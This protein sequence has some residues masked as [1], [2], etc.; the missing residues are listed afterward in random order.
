MGEI[1]TLRKADG[2]VAEI[3]L[4]ARRYLDSARQRIADDGVKATLKAGTSLAL[5]HATYPA[6]VR[7]Q[8]RRTFTFRGTS[9]HYETS[10]WNNAWLNER[11]V[12]IAVARNVLSGQTGSMLEVGNVLGHYGWDRHVILDLF[13]GL[14]GVI[15]EDVRTW[16]TDQRFST[17]ASISTLE[18]VGWDDPVKDPRGAVASV[19]NLRTLLS[20][21]GLLLVTVPLGYNRFLDSALGSKELEFDEMIYLER[22]SAANDWT[23]TTAESALSRPYGGRFRNGNAILVGIDR[24][25]D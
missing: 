13:E 21:G 18:H 12:E 6:T 23:E 16:Q 8:R 24:R 9:L 11:A 10:R 19:E 5:A 14:P 17:I 20:P 2:R 1:S 7:Q 15:N 4:E 22:T 25:V 3:R